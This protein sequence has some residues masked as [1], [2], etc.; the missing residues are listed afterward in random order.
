[1]YTPT[2]RGALFG[3]LTDRLGAAWQGN[4]KRRSFTRLALHLDAAA[5]QAHD[6]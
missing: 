6:F 3:Y 4:D 1:L 5:M 2:G